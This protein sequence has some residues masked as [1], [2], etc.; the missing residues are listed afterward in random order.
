MTNRGGRRDGAGRKRIERTPAEQRQYEEERRRMKKLSQQKSRQKQKHSWLR[1]PSESSTVRAVPQP[2]EHTIEVVDSA[3]ER[4]IDQPAAATIE[5]QHPPITSNESVPDSPQ[6]IPRVDDPMM[7]AFDGQVPLACNAAEIDLAVD[8]DIDAQ[9][10]QF[11]LEFNNLEENSVVW[12]YV[13]S[14]TADIAAGGYND[15]VKAGNSWIM[16]PD[17]VITLRAALMDGK[18]P[19]PDVFYYPRI[20]IFE[21]HVMYP[22]IKVACPLCNKESKPKGWAH[23]PRRIVD[24]DDCFFLQSRRYECTSESCKHHF[25]AASSTECMQAFPRFIQLCFPALLSKRSGVSVSLLSLISKSVDHGIGP[26]ALAA[27]VK[28]NHTLRHTVFETQYY[29]IIQTYLTGQ[30]LYVYSFRQKL[31]DDSSVVP[32]FS[33]FAE[34]TGYSGF[35]PS[36]PYLMSVFLRDTERKRAYF[37][38]EVQRRS[39]KVYSFD[40][41]FKVTKHIHKVNGTKTFEGLHTGG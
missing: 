21:P 9:C 12:N 18:N 7:P 27:M 41:S 30:Q 4:P 11:E 25:T 31:K 1:P 10:E 8:A 2:V 3:V 14:K 24:M 6:F 13:K 38:L 20:Y 5:E 16:P 36:A 40:H 28:E 37:D 17:P 35:T 33:S 34:K 32:K 19:S 15:Q 26:T 22:G 29:N 23:S 39:G